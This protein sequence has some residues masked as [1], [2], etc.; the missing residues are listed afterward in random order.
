[1]AENEEMNRGLEAE[2]EKSL[3]RWRYGK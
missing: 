1:M 2:N 3:R